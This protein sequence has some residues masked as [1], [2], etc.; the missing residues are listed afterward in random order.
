MLGQES[1]LFLFVQ[2]DCIGGV[3]VAFYN[4][5]DTPI[6]EGYV[7]RRWPQAH[8]TDAYNFGSILTFIDTREA[9]GEASDG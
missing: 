7:R 2:W 9:S 1:M 4:A 5:D 6:A 8:H 3:H